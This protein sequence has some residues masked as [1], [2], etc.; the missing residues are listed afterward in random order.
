MKELSTNDCYQNPPGLIK[1]IVNNCPKIKRLSTYLEPK[2]FIHVKILLLNCK[3]L[4]DIWFGSSLSHSN[5]NMGD[6]LLDILTEFSPESL[7]SIRISGGWKC[8]IDGFKRFF[9]SCRE[10]SLSYF[11]FIIENIYYT[12]PHYYREIVRKYV[13]EGVIMESNVDEFFIL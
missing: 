2:D 12:T 10:R 1:A 11:G 4:E 6:K 9:E 7:K 8:S 5:N 3:Y 13:K